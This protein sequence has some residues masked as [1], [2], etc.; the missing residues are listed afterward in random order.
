MLRYLDIFIVALGAAVLLAL[1]LPLIGYGVG[2]GFWLVLRGLATVVDHQ[3]RAFK[4][5]GRQI[6]LRM[7]VRFARTASLVA[8]AVLAREAGG[9]HA[10][11]IAVLAMTGG[12]VAELTVSAVRR[13]SAAT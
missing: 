12:F 7:A 11:L 5:M 2:A 3:S 9:N 6:S 1:R 10:A 4:D 8:A 13:R